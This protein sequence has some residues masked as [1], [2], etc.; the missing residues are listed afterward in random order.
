MTRR[1]SGGLGPGVS[2]AEGLEI[3][4]LD[5]GVKETGGRAGGGVIVQ[6]GRQ[7][8]DCGAVRA[9]WVAPGFGDPIL[10]P[11]RAFK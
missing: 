6:A 7:E 2:E 5:V 8:L 1:P 3:Q 11:A 10:S 9:A 4:P